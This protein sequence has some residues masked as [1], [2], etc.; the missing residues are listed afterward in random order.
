MGGYVQILIFV[1]IGIVFLWFGYSLFFG[2]GLSGKKRPN[3]LK[4]GDPASPGDPQVCPICSSRLSKGD[5]VQ[6][7]AYPSVSGGKDRLMH[8]QGCLHCLY[9]DLE[10]YC[11]VCGAPLGNDD[12]LVA[13]MFERRNR[14]PHVHVLGCSHCRKM[15]IL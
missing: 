8:V 13:R 12:I 4:G 15:G 6:T 11:P 10:R 3:L 9:G 14:H 2:R 5:L 7:M 1:T